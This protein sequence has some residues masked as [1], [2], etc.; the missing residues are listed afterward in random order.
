MIFKILLVL[1]FTLFS[2]VCLGIE[3]PT[4]RLGVL[5]SGTLAWE[6]A[7]IK[8][9][10]GLDNAGFNLET[11]A[12]ANQQAGKVAL[13]AGSVD[14]IV[15]DWIWV[16]SMRAQGN[17]YTFYP[18]SASAGGLL[19][20]ADS[21]IK[22][23]SDLQGKKLGIAGGELD[24]NWSLLQALGLQQGLNLN[25][26][27]EKVYGAPPL[28][29]QQ[30]SSRRVDALLTY[31][32][33]AARL[34]A[35]GYRQLM[36]GE[37]II[38]ALGITE[39]VPSLGYVFKQSWA[40]QHKTALQDFLQTAQKAKDSLCD[41]DSAWQQV[42]DLTASPDKDTQAL[43]RRRYCQGRVKQWGANEQNAAERIYHLLHRLS[44]NKLTG[45]TA[46][47]QPGTFWSA[48]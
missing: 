43:L 48:D 38:R 10:T 17:D 36:S 19:V 44:D 9:A 27:L 23:L 31:W 1:L 39:T 45:K 5:A 16:S 47:L 7:A 2:N 8:N 40:D 22:N 35:Q 4:I 15:S 33:F 20:P 14:I 37:D 26:S 18:Y 24:K 11:V 28:L 30:L 25:Q 12:I 34:E 21:N 6:L 29:N 41:S 46:Q 13:Q 3:K 42:A 32:Q